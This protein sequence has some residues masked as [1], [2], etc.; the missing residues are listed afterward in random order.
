M[1]P[2]SFLEVLGYVPDPRGRHGRIHS[3][4][5]ILALTVLTMLHGC[6]GPTAISQFGRVHG[7][8]LAHLLGFRRVKTPAP[9]CLSDLYRAIDVVAFEAALSKWI[10][11]RMPQNTE[12]QLVSLDGK[13]LRGSHD[14]GASGQHVVSAHA[15]EQQA[16]LA[17]I[18]VDAKTNEHKAALELHGILPV[19]GRI[20]LG[21]AMFGQRDLCAKPAACGGVGQVARAGG[22]RIGSNGAYADTAFAI[23]DVDLGLPLPLFRPSGTSHPTPSQ[24]LGLLDLHSFVLSGTSKLAFQKIMT[25][26]CVSDAY[27]HSATTVA[28]TLRVMVV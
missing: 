21:D 25:Y 3:L 5:A 9:S 4:S 23:R 24:P 13:N 2:L 16:V 18:R 14:G 22:R 15:H 28:I 17:Q 19:K 7:I 1:A 6:K 10:A 20:V 8:A 12:K 11:S 27:R 26:I